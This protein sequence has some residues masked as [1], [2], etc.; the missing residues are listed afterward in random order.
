MLTV[1]VS[2]FS[3]LYLILFSEI[4]MTINNLIPVELDINYKTTFEIVNNICIQIKLWYGINNVKILAVFIIFF[5]TE[6]LRWLY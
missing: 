6:T 1:G 2:L 4:F 3:I 5:S